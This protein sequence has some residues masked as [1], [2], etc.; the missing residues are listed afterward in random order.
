V[1]SSPFSRRVKP[2]SSKKSIGKGKKVN[3]KIRG[4]GGEKKTK[5]SRKGGKTAKHTGKG[6]KAHQG[7]P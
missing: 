6:Q 7:T 5:P 3:N 4:Q 1:Q 2:A